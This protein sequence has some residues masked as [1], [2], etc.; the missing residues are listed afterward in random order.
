MEGEPY[1]IS[2]TYSDDGWGDPLTGYN[3][4]TVTS[5]AI[6]NMLSDGT[7]TYTWEHG[8]ELASMSKGTTTWNYTYNADGM[9]TQ[10]SNGTDTYTYVYN[11]SQLTQM[12][13]GSDTLYFSY[14]ASGTPMTVTWNGTTYYYVTNIE[15]DVIAILDGTGN[16]VVTYEYECWGCLIFAGYSSSLYTLNP[17]RYRGYVFDCETGLYYLQSRYYDPELGRFI[18][19]DGQISGV[20]GDLLGYN[21]FAYCFNNPVNM[22]DTSGNW[23]KWLSGV[24]NVVSGVAQAAVGAV[25]GATVGWTGVGAVAAAALILNGAATATQGIGQIVN[26]ATQSNVLREDN[27]IRTGV[28]AVGG[29]I[30]GE[31]GA[32]VAGMVY[33]TGILVATL[34][35]P[36]AKVASKT[37]ASSTSATYNLNGAKGIDYVTNRGWNDDMINNAISNGHRGT[38]INLANGESCTAYRYPGTNNQYVV[39]ENISRKLVQVSDFY[40]SGWIPDSRIIWDP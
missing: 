23:P 9:R 5:D 28:Q 20:G 16:S 7:W 25:L 38:S 3:G 39:I 21:Q 29:A 34:Y 15:G 32:T 11:G 8:R 35:A 1:T 30:G 36:T 26:A 37:I 13:K 19:A 27:I 4:K 6:G 17:L 24:A 40:D 33:D 12:T 14:D 2:Y 10:R 31:T 22:S 18:S